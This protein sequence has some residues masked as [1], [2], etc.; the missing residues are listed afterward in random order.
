MAD[1]EDIRS[2][3]LRLEEQSPTGF[4]IAFHVKFTTPEF[5]LQTYPKEWIDLYSERGYV[6]VDPTV[7]WGFNNEGTKR[8]SELADDDSVGIFKECQK[9]NMNYGVS[10]ALEQGGSRSL[11]SFTRHDRDFAEA[12]CQE[13]S[14]LLEKLHDMTLSDGSMSA[15][16][17]QNL[18]DLS[19]Q[20]THP[21]W[22]KS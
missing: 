9:F 11:A 22:R 21:D 3:L 13:L 19:V 14:E 20:M 18:H 4:A 7:S 5:L 8:W 2:I 1:K 10:V 17:R 12:E 16:Q 6:M 15:E